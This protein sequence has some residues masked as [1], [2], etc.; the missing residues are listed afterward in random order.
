MNDKEIVKRKLVNLSYPS[1]INGQ[2]G[3][4]EFSFFESQLDFV[5]SEIFKALDEARKTPV[6]DEQWRV[7]SI[8]ASMTSESYPNLPAWWTQIRCG[9]KVVARIFGDT[10]EESNKKA[11]VV[12]MAV[13]GTKTLD[14]ARRN[15]TN[16]L[17]T[18]ERIQES[19]IDNIASVQIN[20]D[21]S[22]I[23]AK[24]LEFAS[25]AFNIVKEG[26]D[27]DGGDVQDKFE[28]LGLIEEKLTNPEDNEWGASKL[29]FWKEYALN[30]KEGV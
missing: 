3:E 19:A 9:D 21:N 16:R 22:K 2:D 25:W 27:I 13:N 18:H 15:N 20:S 5:S 1:F 4:R 26:Q 11:A 8:P 12:V 29:Y 10:P 17:M 14:E 24:L 28:E 23:N 30:G 7:G 6:N